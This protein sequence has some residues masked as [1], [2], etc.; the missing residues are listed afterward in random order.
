VEESHKHVDAS[1]ARNVKTKSHVHVVRIDEPS[2]DTA[3]F[4][5]ELNK[6]STV[7]PLSENFAESKL[8]GRG[9]D[10]K[11]STVTGAYETLYALLL[12]PETIIANK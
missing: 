6:T 2:I 1:A 9:L 5:G 4:D 8:G 10:V 12:K 7:D 3:I 11:P